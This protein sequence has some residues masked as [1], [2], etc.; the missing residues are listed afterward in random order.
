MLSYKTEM[1]H[2]RSEIPRLNNHH[3]DT[4]RVYRNDIATKKANNTKINKEKRELNTDY[5]HL[6]TKIQVWKTAYGQWR[7]SPT[8]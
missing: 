4:I 5:K 6:E 2:S 1:L 7:G 3:V 8:N